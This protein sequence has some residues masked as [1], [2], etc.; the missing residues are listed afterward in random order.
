MK[1]IQ[2]K[3][4]D[5]YIQAHMAMGNLQEQNINCWLQDEYSVTIDPVLTNAI[6]GIKLMVAEAQAQRAAD[7]LNYL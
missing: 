7:I 2:I 4:F 3:S 6:G 5:N 1:F